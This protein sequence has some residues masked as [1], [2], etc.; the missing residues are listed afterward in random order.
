MHS[1]NIIKIYFHVINSQTEKRMVIG[2]GLIATALKLFEADDSV[3]IFASGV[4]NSGETRTEAY[5]REKNL[6]LTQQ[7]SNARLIYFSTCS[8]FDTSLF[9]SCYIIHKK[10]MEELVVRHFDNYLLIRLPILIGRTSNPNTFFNFIRNRII[11][12]ESFPVHKH[13]WRY[14]FDVDDLKRFLPLFLKQH[15]SGKE[16]I[17]LAFD[18]GISVIKLV[19]LFE[20]ILCMKANTELINKGS[21]YEFNCQPF[22]SFLQKN[23]FDYDKENYNCNVLN[24][25]LRT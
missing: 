20:N 6:L 11:N 14:L 21:K 5:E 7:T 4:S 12:N 15:P 25:Y 2:K 19:E 22:F 3:L 8:V 23:N 24:K 10:E 9:S 17:N 13:A 16:I 18:N 1:K